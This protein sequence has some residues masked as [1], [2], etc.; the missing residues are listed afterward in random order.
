[1]NDRKYN[2]I[3]KDLSNLKPQITWNIIGRTRVRN[4]F[5]FSNL[6]SKISMSKKI[7]NR[8]CPSIDY[9][10]MLTDG[11]ARRSASSGRLAATFKVNIK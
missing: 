6:L 5:N 1:M 7:G 10:N 11:I 4:L 9:T 2:V 8:N 3:T